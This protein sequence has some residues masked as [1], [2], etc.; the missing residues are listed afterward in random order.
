MIYEEAGLQLDIEPNAAYLRVHG[1]L[2]EVP[3]SIF[4]LLDSARSTS[5]GLAVVDLSEARSIDSQTIQW[6]ERAFALAEREGVRFQIVSPSGT[7][8]RRLIELLRLHRFVEMVETPA[9]LSLAV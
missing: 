6:I 3:L 7:K 8:P 4:A 5:S 1:D 9:T 2:S